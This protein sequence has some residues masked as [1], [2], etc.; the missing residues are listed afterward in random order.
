[1][2][3]RYLKVRSAGPWAL[4]ICCHRAKLAG[5]SSATEGCSGND[6]VLASHTDLPQVSRR[7]R[8]ASK[9]LVG[10]KRLFDEKALGRA[11][12]KGL[13]GL[14][15][16]RPRQRGVV[17]ARALSCLWRCCKLYAEGK[18][19]SILSVVRSPVCIRPS[20]MF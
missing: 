17:L 19:K 13:V 1:V 7:I 5:Q 16:K 10:E 12:E 15:I 4:K 9:V 6:C 20:P 2:S 14:Q 3:F 18:L 11:E 8:P